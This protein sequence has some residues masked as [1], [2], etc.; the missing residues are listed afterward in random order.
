MASKKKNGFSS[1][2]SADSNHG[3][4]LICAKKRLEVLLDGL[5]IEPELVLDDDVIPNAIVPVGAIRVCPAAFRSGG[6]IGETAGRA[7]CLQRDESFRECI[8]LRLRIQ[9]ASD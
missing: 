6:A 7:F 8:P 3:S 2:F 9:P 5:E 4:R 1:S